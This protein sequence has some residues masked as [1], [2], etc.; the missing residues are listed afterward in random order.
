MT[1]LLIVV[2]CLAAAALEMCDEVHPRSQRAHSPAST[3]VSS[4]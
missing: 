4:R 2:A 3:H 1:T